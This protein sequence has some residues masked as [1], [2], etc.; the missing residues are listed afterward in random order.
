MA[1]YQRLQVGRPL[2][3]LAASPPPVAPRD[4]E[5]LCGTTE[6]AETEGLVGKTR[7]RDKKKCY[8]NEC[9]YSLIFWLSLTEGRAGW[10]TTEVTEDT[11]G[12]DEAEAVDEAI[13]GFFLPLETKGFRCLRQSCMLS[14]NQSQHSEHLTSMEQVTFLHAKQIVCLSYY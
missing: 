9:T 11:S 14:T 10:L 12:V 8:R 2:F 6:G 13:A 4:G 1:P 3:R 5:E 7:G